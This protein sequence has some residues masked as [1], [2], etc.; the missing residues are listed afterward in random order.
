MDPTMMAWLAM[1]AG[2][3]P[4]VAGPLMDQVLPPPG[5]MNLGGP[6]Q[7]VVPDTPSLIDPMSPQ[8]IGPWTTTVNPSPQVAPTA[9]PAAPGGL[10]AAQM[11]GLAGMQG[12]KAPAPITPLMHGGVQGGVKPPDMTAKM[13]GA[14]SSPAI[15]ALMHALLGGGGQDPLRVPTLGSLVGRR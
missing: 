2:S 11:L 7:D 1:L 3:K 9:D 10:S 13:G 6:V 4:E 8:A 14:A 12:I 15:A 5:K